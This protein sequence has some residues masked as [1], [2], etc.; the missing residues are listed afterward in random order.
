MSNADAR[1]TMQRW[2]RQV[3]SL[4]GLAAKVAPKV[5]DKLRTA[6]L[7]NYV[8]QRGPDGTPWEPA[9]DGRTMLQSAAGALDVSAQSTVITARIRSR[10][11]YRHHA[12]IARGRKRR[13]LL[14]T[15]D[16][17]QPVS[18]AIKA[19]LTEQF[20]AHMGGSDG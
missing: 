15:R 12:G 3:R 18:D 19:V 6:L 2:V 11:L 17:P 14:P 1:A 16:L 8:A 7:A 10:N 13:P 20:G 5:A 4:P 9:N